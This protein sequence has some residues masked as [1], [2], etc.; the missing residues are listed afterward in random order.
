MRCSNCGWENKDTNKFCVKCGEKM[1]ADTSPNISKNTGKKNKPKAIILI[2]VAVLTVIISVALII[3]HSAKSLPDSNNKNI[4][5]S[6]AASSHT[7]TDDALTTE[8]EYTDKKAEDDTTTTTATKKSNNKEYFFENKYYFLIDD[9]GEL[10]ICVFEFKGDSV[11]YTV[12]DHTEGY[13]KPGFTANY[14]LKWNK[15][16]TYAENDFGMRFVVDYDWKVVQYKTPDM[17]KLE[18]LREYS[19]LS[20]SNLEEFAMEYLG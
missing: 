11:K 16:H 7:G 8:D 19:E 5:L 2:A 3:N 17:A 9:A 4:E 12:Y 14:P 6:E 10:C 15:D 13:S 20:Q 1:N 18:A